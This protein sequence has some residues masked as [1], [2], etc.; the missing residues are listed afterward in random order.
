MTFTGIWL[1]VTGCEWLPLVFQPPY[2]VAL[3]C[4]SN[5]IDA[6]TR[7]CVSFLYTNIMLISEG[8]AFPCTL[9]SLIFGSITLIFGS[10]IDAILFG[11]VVDSV[12]SL[13]KRQASFN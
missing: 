12:Q 4:F 5:E 1:L 10:F 13:H 3:V 6:V 8:D 2:E 9:N 11:V 7:F